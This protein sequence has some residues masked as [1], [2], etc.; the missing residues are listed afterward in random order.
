MWMQFPKYFVKFFRVLSHPA[1]I[2]MMCKQYYLQ[3]QRKCETSSFAENCM[4][5]C[6]F[7]ECCPS[8]CCSY[9]N[10]IKI[11]ELQINYNDNDNDKLQ[12]VF[13]LR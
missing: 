6:V 7:L 5:N 1:Q 12:K 3:Q 9:P 11:S 4:C 10:K 2:K 8:K 13:L